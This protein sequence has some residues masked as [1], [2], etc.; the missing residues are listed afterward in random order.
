MTKNEKHENYMLRKELKERREKV[1]QVR[2][3]SGKIVLEQEA[4]NPPARK[5]ESPMKQE[6]KRALYI[7]IT[8]STVITNIIPIYTVFY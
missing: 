2:L 3:Q 7:I 8:I 6:I 4:R 5:A 1:E